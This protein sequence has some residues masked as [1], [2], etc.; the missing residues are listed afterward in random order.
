MVGQM[1]SMLEPSL[2]FHADGAE[3]NETDVRFLWDIRIVKGKDTFFGHV[4]GTSTMA[5][6]LAESQLHLAVERVSNEM[7]SKVSGPV[8]GKFQDLANA[9][10]LELL[11][12][13][14]PRQ[15]SKPI[16]LPPPASLDLDLAVE[17]EIISQQSEM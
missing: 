10:A 11:E 7:N 15:G 4:T 6:L 1:Q 3:A 5:G 17:A 12:L 2:S 14:N 9:R 8:A 13:D 16:S